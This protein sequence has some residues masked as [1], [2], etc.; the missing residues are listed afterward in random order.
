MLVPGHATAAGQRP[1]RAS[2]VVGGDADAHPRVH[3]RPAVSNRPELA[4]DFGTIDARREVNGDR[5]RMVDGCS[6]GYAP[7]EVREVGNQLRR[8]RGSDGEPTVVRDR[9]APSAVRT[10]HDT[11]C[12][13]NSC[14]HP[15]DS[16]HNRR[17]PDPRLD[18]R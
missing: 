16:P 11:G 18:K 10:L 17:L 12:R 13:R 9:L 6:P 5:A 8:D 1:V 14:S 3:F 15:Y 7:E 4:F 2:L